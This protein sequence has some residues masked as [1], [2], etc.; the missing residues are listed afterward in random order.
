MRLAGHVEYI[1]EKMNA[2]EI[3]VGKQK[4]TEH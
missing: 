2:C 3:L 4:E 1:R